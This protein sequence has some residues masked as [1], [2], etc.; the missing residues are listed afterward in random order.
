MIGPRTWGLA[1]L[2][3]G[4]VLA[5]MPALAQ[6]AAPALKPALAGEEEA[7]APIIPRLTIGPETDEAAAAPRRRLSPENP[8]EPVGI[9]A[10]VFRLYPSLTIGVV[11]TSNP[12]RC[13]CPASEPATGL[14]LTPALRLESDWVRHR[15]TAAAKF[16]TMVYDE[17][18]Y[19]TTEGEAEVDLR[20]DIRRTTTFDLGASYAR[21][22]ASLAG[23]DAPANAIDYR[24]DHAI[25]AEAALTHDFGPLTARL[26]GG[27]SWNLFDDVALAGGGTEDNSDRAYLAPRLAL[28]ATYREPPAFRPYVEV[29]LAPR[30]YFETH[31]RNGLRR[32]SMGYEVRIGS[33]WDGGAI[34]QGDLAATYLRR[35]Y[36]DPALG[37]NSAL[38]LTG[39][40]AWS[41]TELTRLVLGLETELTDTVGTTSAGGRRWQARLD[42]SH[43]LRD[44]V[45]LSAGLG[46]ELARADGGDDVSYEAEAA[47][48]WTMTPTLSWALTYD[49]VTLDAAD[50]ARDYHDHR[51]GAALT[52][53]R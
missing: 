37:S 13:N 48:A 44:N 3:A 43:A 50:P 28:R 24:T 21:D 12:L 1:G 53:R 31:D 9:D 45:T 30:H 4:L 25:G 46:V 18:A 29:G 34:W 7:P 35:D 38:G 52:L 20:L 6:E 2:A 33:E 19:D 36:D 22:Q 16:T 39:T 5:A 23:S 49:F 32:S 47:L 41:P 17:S 26:K 40:L 42:G 15:L 10:G 51:L 8:W 11:A 14:A 27:L